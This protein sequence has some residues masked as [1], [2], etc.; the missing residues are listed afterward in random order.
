MINGYRLGIRVPRIPVDPSLDQYPVLYYH[1]VLDRVITR[2]IHVWVDGRT[3]IARRSDNLTLGGVR[4]PESIDP[5]HE[6]RDN[7]D[8]PTID[9]SAEQFERYWEAAFQRVQRKPSIN[10]EK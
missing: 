5:V 3:G 1:E 6:R 7:P 8:L 9:L 10:I 4:L 2:V